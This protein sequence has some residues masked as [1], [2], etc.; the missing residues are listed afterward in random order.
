MIF[1]NLEQVEKLLKLKKLLKKKIN[2]YREA[3]WLPKKTILYKKQ[4]EKN[5]TN[6][7]IIF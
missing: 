4:G 6:K 3:F 7:Q 1:L 5:G 2:K